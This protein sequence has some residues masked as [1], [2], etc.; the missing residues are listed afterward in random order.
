M[1]LYLTGKV[2]V[3]TGGTT[4]IGRECAK[5]LCRKGVSRGLRALKGK[6][7]AFEKKWTRW[8]FRISA[9]AWMY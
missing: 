1:D 9:K 3:I 7:T 8:G 6:N 4:G 5:I 2:V